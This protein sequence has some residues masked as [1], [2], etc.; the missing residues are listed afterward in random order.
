M[1]QS[2]SYL[3]DIIIFS[4]LFSVIFLANKLCVFCYCFGVHIWIFT[5]VLN[6]WLPCRAYVILWPVIRWPTTAGPIAKISN[7]HNSATR[8]PIPSMFGFRVVFSEMTDRTAP[9]PVVSGRH[10]VNSHDHALSL[11]VGLLSDTRYV[12]IQTILC[13]RTV[14]LLMH[15]IG[16]WSTPISQERVT[17]RPNL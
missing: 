8:H 6:L 3:I 14:W 9:F 17:S 4:L 12:C 2:F 5:G 16:D 10:F 15:M 11:K 1:M 13:P 7:G